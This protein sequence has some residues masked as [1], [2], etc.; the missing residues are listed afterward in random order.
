M[1]W[2]VE[3]LLRVRVGARAPGWYALGRAHL[4]LDEYQAAREQLEAAWQAGYREPGVA[5]AYGVTLG[6]LYEHGLDEERSSPYPRLPSERI[7]DLE[8]SLRNPA[9]VRLREGAG[10]EGVPWS[11]TVG[12]VARY[13]DRFQDALDAALRCLEEGPWFYEA[14]VLQGDVHFELAEHAL[15][16]GSAEA[17]S[18]A[19]RDAEQSYRTA[20]DIAASDPETYARSCRLWQRVLEARLAA[21]NGDL[22]APLASAVAACNRALAVDPRRTAERNVK[23]ASH[24]MFAERQLEDGHDPAEQTAAARDAAQQVLEIDPENPTALRLW[25]TT[26]SLAVERWRRQDSEQRQETADEV[27][28]WTVLAAESLLK[29]AAQRPQDPG[30]QIDLGRALSRRAAFLDDQGLDSKQVLERARDAFGRAVELGPG[31]ADPHAENAGVLLQAARSELGVSGDPLALYGEAVANADRAIELRPDHYRAHHLCGLAHL[32]RA[33]YMG[34]NGEDQRAD[35]EAAVESFQRS[36]SISPDFTR[37]ELALAHSA[38]LLA[39][40]QL[41]AGDDPTETLIVGRA[42]AEHSLRLT[43]DDPERQQNLGVLLAL[44]AEASPHRDQRLWWGERAVDLLERL[45]AERRDA[46]VERQLRRARAVADGHSG[47]GA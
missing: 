26:Y 20:A 44:S 19:F 18:D 35:L 34:T 24:L 46:A 17:A 36:L 5:W 1:A 33:E 43:P 45:P 42:A 22:Q 23:A 3:E 31:T 14:W 9:L 15:E 30:F 10:A 7:A 6:R 13:E 25:G 39:E 12:L 40:H 29:A 2:I 4:V 28:E 41:A 32:G 11:Y 47:G 21:G 27:A 16:R 37:A 38:G 8:R